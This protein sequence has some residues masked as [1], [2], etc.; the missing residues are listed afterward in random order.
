MPHG[1]RLPG[2]AAHLLLAPRAARDGAQARSCPRPSTCPTAAAWGVFLRNHDEL[3]LEMVSEEYRQAMYG[4]YGY[5]P[6]MRS[7]IGIRRRLAPLLDNSRAELE[8]VH[9]LLF[10]LPGSPVPVLRRRDRHGRQHLAAG[11]RLLPHADAVDARPQR[12]VLHRRPG[13]AL[14]ARRAVARLQLRAGQRRGAARAVAVAAALGP[15]RHPRA[16]GAPGVRPRRRSQ[17]QET[18]TSACS[19]SSARGRAPAPSSGPPPRT[20]CACSRSR[21][22][23]RRPRSRRRSSPGVRSYDLFGGGSF[24]SFDDDG[25]V[26]LTLGT[27]S[28]YWLHVAPRPAPDGGSRGACRCVALA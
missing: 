13:Q 28:F 24:P 4:W 12:R 2:H 15:Q 26:T 3:T 11:P 7:N 1:V 8:L 23:R 6:R 27:Q 16:E 21:T 14:P 18:D 5:D 19:R 10:S 22:T 17:V 9:A 25:K 20:S